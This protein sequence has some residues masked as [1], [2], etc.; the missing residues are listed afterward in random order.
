MKETSWKELILSIISWMTPSAVPCIGAILFFA[1]ACTL[2]LVRYFR[3]P[4]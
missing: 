1:A 4:D 3:N 2:F